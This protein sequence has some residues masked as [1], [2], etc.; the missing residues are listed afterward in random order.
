MK[1]LNKLQKIHCI[2][3]KQAIE[4]TYYNTGIKNNNVHLPF[5]LINM[6]QTVNN[7][8]HRKSVL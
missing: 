8:N 1:N 5:S 4:E 2:S 3:H 7:K 6:S